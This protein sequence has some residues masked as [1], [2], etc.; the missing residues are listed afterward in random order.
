MWAAH[1]NEPHG[2]EL[3]PTLMILCFTAGSETRCSSLMGEGHSFS[4]HRCR[5]GNGSTDTA[6]LWDREGCRV[7]TRT[8]RGE[9]GHQRGGEVPVVGRSACSS[10]PVSSRHQHPATRPLHL[11]QECPSPGLSPAPTAPTLRPLLTM[12]AGPPGQSRTPLNASA[13]ITSII[14]LAINHILPRDTYSVSSC[15]SEVQ[16]FDFPGVADAASLI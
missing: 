8:P 9:W 11:L 5:S 2:I 6:G 14:H 4:T 3:P 15:Y 10:A 13:I 1:Q 7:Q 16:L 12:P